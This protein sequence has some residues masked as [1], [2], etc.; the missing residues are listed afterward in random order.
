[1]FTVGWLQRCLQFIPF[2]HLSIEYRSVFGRYFR[3]VSEFNFL[4]H[5]PEALGR[6]VWGSFYGWRCLCGTAELRQRRNCSVYNGLLRFRIPC[7]INHLKA[8]WCLN[9][10]PNYTWWNCTF[11]TWCKIFF[12]IAPI[13][14]PTPDHPPHSV[15][16]TS[17][18]DPMVTEPLNLNSLIR[19]T[20]NWNKE[21]IQTEVFWAWYSVYNLMC[22]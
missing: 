5:L 3:S 16:T 10:N 21:Q 6:Y 4:E 22:G 7:C 9:E 19:R 13:G 15:V 14:T 8:I 17:T 11:F 2:Y 1:M 20:V 12:S 18:Y